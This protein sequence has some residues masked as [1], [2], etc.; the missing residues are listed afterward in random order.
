[1]RRHVKLYV[2]G[3]DFRRPCQAFPSQ[4]S[5]LRLEHADPGNMVASKGMLQAVVLLSGKLF[6]NKVSKCYDLVEEVP[7]LRRLS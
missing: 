6:I 7:P 3:L 5:F 4:T 2:R 1:M